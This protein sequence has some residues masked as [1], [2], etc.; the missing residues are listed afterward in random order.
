MSIIIKT[1]SESETKN[2][3]L[4]LSRELAKIK[5]PAVILCRG[6]LGTGKT[7]FIQ[8]FAKGLGV[9]GKV[10]S[11]SFTLMKEYKI[12]KAGFRK[13]YHIDC[14]RVNS[15]REVKS[16][17]GREEILEKPQNIVIIE[18]GERAD[19]AINKKTAD[20]YFQTEGESKRTIKIIWRKKESL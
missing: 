9:K 15:S 8:G 13:L 4:K 20:I 3:G 12:K 18:W 14:Y 1:E 6:D 11:P 7:T 5:G 10:K 16:L 17:I 19:G 2:E